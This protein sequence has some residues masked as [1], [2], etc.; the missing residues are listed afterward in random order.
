MPKCD[1][2]GCEKESLK[3]TSTAFDKAEEAE[4]QEE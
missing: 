4:E 1:L 2:K 3:P